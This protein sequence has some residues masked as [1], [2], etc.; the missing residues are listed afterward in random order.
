VNRIRLTASNFWCYR[1]SQ[2]QL[3]WLLISLV[4]TL[5]WSGS[6]TAAAKP[7]E[8]IGGAFDFGYV[9]SGS[10]LRHTVQIVNRSDSLLRV[11]RT[12]PGCGCTKISL[13]PKAVAPGE[14]LMVEMS[15]DLAK[16]NAGQFVK[17]PAILLSDPALGKVSI[18]LSGFGYRGGDIAAPMRVTPGS[19]NFKRRGSGEAEVEIRNLGAQDV[20]V[21]SVKIPR[22]S[23]CSVTMPP[24][25]IAKG[26][27][28][29]IKI[30]LNMAAT[31]N[32]SQE[33]LTF[34]LTDDKMTRFTVPITIAE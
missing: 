8:V 15:L 11:V 1:K 7:S 4:L 20:L 29:K 33:S 24:R 23:F 17:A 30:K 18:R 27:S 32:E 31:V 19:V 5:L 12:M 14:T 3:W 25:S 13:P 16:V 28:D 9:P 10:L 2:N 6:I 22:Q 26:S 21:R 34:Y